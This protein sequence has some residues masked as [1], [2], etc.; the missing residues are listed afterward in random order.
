MNFGDILLESKIDLA[1]LGPHGNS[2]AGNQIL[3]D[4]NREIPGDAGFHV[5]PKAVFETG[6]E[7]RIC[8]VHFYPSP[9]HVRFPDR[10]VDVSAT[11]SLAAQN[12]LNRFVIDLLERGFFKGVALLIQ[13]ESQSSSQCGFR[14]DRL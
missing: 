3:S 2:H 4:N 14:S 6:P 13:I 8:R 7:L 9:F 12:D 11:Q 1:V 5:K 10:G